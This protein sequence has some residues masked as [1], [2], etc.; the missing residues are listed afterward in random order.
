MNPR[1][2]LAQT[3]LFGALAASHRRALAEVSLPV[4]VTRRT[5]LFEEGR[6]GDAFYVAAR[7]RVQLHKTAPDGREIVIKVVQPGETFA[8]VILFEEARYPVTAVALTDALLL[9]ILRRDVLRLLADA[10][11]RADFIAMLMR[12]QR[13][14]AERIRQLATESVEERFL[15]FLREQYGPSERIELAIPRKA[16]AAAIG[17]TPETLSRLLRR[18]QAAKTLSCRGRKLAFRPG[19]WNR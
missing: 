13:Y 17:A 11:F 2:L 8:E 19:F 10:D 12:K 14:L 4:E 3:S 5:V 16:L 6:K 1:F 18:L 7:G 9:K 15:Q